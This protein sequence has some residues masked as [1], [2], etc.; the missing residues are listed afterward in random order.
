M[1]SLGMFSAAEVYDLAILTEQNGRAFYE[2]ASAAAT[3]PRVAKLLG[4]LAEAEHNH[5]TT[6]RTMKQESPGH[7]PRETYE[8]ETTEYMQALLLSRV[9][10]D[11]EAGKRAV[12][13]MKQDVDALD[14]ALGFEK[15][16]ILFLYEMREIVSD[17]EKPRIDLLL[18]QEKS[19]VQLLTQLKRDLGQHE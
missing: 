9:L 7:P 13:N 6:F 19:H 2:A 16:T 12:A 1:S 8:G 10:P 17:A 5:E 15:D 3:A 11:L 14:F 4:Q 18:G